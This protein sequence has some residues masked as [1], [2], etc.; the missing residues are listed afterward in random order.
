MS[1]KELLRLLD[2]SFNKAKKKTRKCL[3]DNCNEEAIKS[4]TLQ[5]NGILKQISEN[6]HLFQFDTVSPFEIERQGKSQLKRIGIND[7]FTFPGFC[8][9]HDSEIFKPIELNNFD[10]KSNESINLFSYRALCQEI[11]RKEIALDFIEN[12]LE[13]IIHPKMHIYWKE[14]KNGLENLY[15]F[16]KELENDLKNPNSK[17]IYKIYEI[18]KTE[19]CIS[20]PLNISDPNNPLSQTHDKNNNVLNNPFVTSVINIFP[21]QEKSYVMIALSKDYHCNWTESLFNKFDGIKSPN[22]L[23]LISDLI[24]TKLEFWCI[25]PQLKNSLTNEKIKELFNTWEKNLSNFSSTL[26][27]KFNLF[28]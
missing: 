19:I 12:M 1:E 6:N 14:L 20:A 17:F 3:I 16:K 4:H 22:H 13:S 18:P 23:K 11:R 8:K 27:I 21:Y 28:E 24:A 26:N 10:I 25:S 7:V 5:K 15:Y 9:Q 2:T